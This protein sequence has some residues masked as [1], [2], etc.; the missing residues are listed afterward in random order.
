MET[1][2]LIGRII[3]GGYFIFESW[4]HF[5]N[6]EELAGYARS[7]GVPAPRLAILGTGLLL[8]VGGAGIVSGMYVLWSILALIL[9]LVPVSFTMHAFWKVAEPNAR[10]AD[11]LHF[12]KNMALVG[13]LLMFFSIPV[14]WPL[15]L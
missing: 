6:I 2:F 1:T 13:A 8:F 5:R 9:F 7:K 10:M 14:P 4:N 15:N 3:F 11:M 12:L